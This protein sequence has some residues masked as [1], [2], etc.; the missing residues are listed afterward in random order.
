MLI[1]LARKT[2]SQQLGTFQPLWQVLKSS[3]EK[4]TSLHMQTLPRLQHLVKEINKYCEDH[5]KRQKQIKN[6]ENATIE[7]MNELK[8]VI[9]SLTKAKEFYYSKVIEVD[10][11][12]KEG[13]ASPK[14]IEKAEARLGKACTEYKV[15]IEKYNKVKDDYEKK[16]CI[17][18]KNFQRLEEDHLKQMKDYLATYSYI[19]ESGHA[20][21]GQVYKE[22][23]R[24]C[25]DMTIDVLMDKF[26]KARGT[27][28]A[29][30][31]EYMAVCFVVSQLNSILFRRGHSV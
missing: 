24:N 19:L 26:I 29:R 25:H 3:T 30:L 16:F 23:Q 9:V 4:V 18:C 15:L 5:Y 11:L 20:L 1:K 12:K 28:N 21:V 17:S 6:E 7:A 13:N 31:S 8:E 2:T 22:F 10:R 14:D 27:G